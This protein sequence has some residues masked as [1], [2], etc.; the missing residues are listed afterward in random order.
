[1][2]RMM[3]AFFFGCSIIGFGIGITMMELK[4][5][6]TSGYRDHLLTLP[7]E[8]FEE[9]I[10]IF[11][12][13]DVD[14]YEIDL[15]YYCDDITGPEKNVVYDKNYTNTILISA[16]YRGIEPEI[17]QSGWGEGADGSTY[18]LFWVD[19]NSFSQAG[20]IYDLAKTMFENKT[21]YSESCLIESIT[22]YTA[23][24]DKIIL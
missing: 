7:L 2:K 3:A 5:W 9:E 20:Q 13:S 24:P 1:M 18:M 19:I 10:P 12:N 23:Y 15:S 11:P 8:T 22:V 4:D 17:F 6:K 21:F 16:N 14:Y